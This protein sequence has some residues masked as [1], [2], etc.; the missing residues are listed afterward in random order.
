MDDMKSEMEMLRK[1]L[2]DVINSLQTLAPV[3]SA[4]APVA[5][6]PAPIVCADRTGQWE[7]KGR[8][9]NWCGWARKQNDT[10]AAC[11]G[12]SLNTDCPV[13]CGVCTP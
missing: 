10:S 3:A 6:T 5:A 8:T 12:R 11:A 9:K 7:I 13:T 2:E 4:P 1:G